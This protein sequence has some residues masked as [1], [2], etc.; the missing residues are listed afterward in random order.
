MSESKCDSDCREDLID[1]IDGRIPNSMVWKA[2][3]LVLAL[4][5]I[6]AGIYSS[7]LTERKAVI[8]EAY[9]CAKTNEKNIE[10]ITNDLTWIKQ[11]QREILRAIKEGNGDT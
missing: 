7:G 3:L 2:V 6:G 11:S 5:G 4:W 10:V 8:A 9:K 1:R